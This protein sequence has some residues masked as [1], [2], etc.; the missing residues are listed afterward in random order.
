M[1][2]DW[3]RTADANG[4]QETV[5]LVQTSQRQI[6]FPK[7][8][9]RFEY[10]VGP[11][12]SGSGEAEKIARLRDAIAA[13]ALEG[14]NPE[15]D[16]IAARVVGYAQM[17]LAKAYIGEPPS[18][19]SVGEH[20]AL[21]SV[22]LTDGTR[23]SLIV[24]QDFVDLNAPDIGDWGIGIK[25]LASPIRSVISGVGRIDIPKRPWFVGTCFVIAPGLVLTNRH[26][27][28][29]IAKPDAYGAWV[30]TEPGTTIDFFA[31]DGNE[32]ATKFKVSG[33]AFA[34]SDPIN[35]EINFVHLDAAVL[36]VDVASS[37][38]HVF[39]PAL[40]L[41]RDLTQPCVPGDIYVVGFPA[42]PKP[43]LYGGAPP[44]GTETVAVLTKLF[45]GKF[46]V[47][48]FAPGAIKS[49]PGS[50]QNDPRGWICSHDASTLGGS[51]GSCVV[52]FAANGSQV[53]GLHFAGASRD[54]NWAHATSHLMQYLQKYVP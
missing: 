14:P 49:G 8:F 1:N 37:P 34:G 41:E 43:W 39:P 54:Q 31:E 16:E 33:V 17:A 53:V 18:A 4:I 47:K 23:P 32:A 28:E 38:P 52:E 3:D 19:F 50:V 25:R 46:G 29:L 7:T 27:L 24:Q 20:A 15:R 26:V 22:I 51:S 12:M 42:Q 6:A 13:A 5:S 35:N 2:I 45:G 11:S 10:S 36:Q 40:R 48:R 30:L 21:E 44:R 9:E